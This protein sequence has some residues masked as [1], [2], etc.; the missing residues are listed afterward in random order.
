[1]ERLSIAQPFPIGR[2]VA[3]GYYRNRGSRQFAVLL[4]LTA[5][6]VGSG[7]A[8][9]AEDASAPELKSFRFSPDTIQTSLDAA[10]LTISFTVTDDDSG[11]TYFEAV[12][13]DQSGTARQSAS[14]RF[15]PTNRAMSSIKVNFPRFSNSGTW[16]LVQLFLSDAAGNTSSWDSEALARRGFPTRLEVVSAKDTVSPKLTALEFSPADP[17]TSAGPA[18]VSVTYTATDDLSGVSYVE[19]GFVSP[20]GTARQSR[21]MKFNASKVIANTMTVVFPAHSEPGQ[22]TL[23]SIFVMDAASNTLVLD[24]KAVEALGF[25]TLLNVRSTLDTVSPTLSSLTFAPSAIDTTGG[26]ANVTA[27]F[28]ATDDMSGVKSFEI[29]FTSPSGAASRSSVVTFAPAKKVTHS[30]SVNFP[31]LS[32]PGSWTLTSVVV[33]DAAGNTLVVDADMLP[34]VV[35]KTLEVR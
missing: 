2:G 21:S 23:N 18:E 27:Q 12:F 5:S 31:R 13:E 19:L 26:E 30:L 11:L 3:D 16:T 14:A 8:F 35:A 32:E 10:E 34:S 28:T 33:T 1:M 24:T 29:V 7:S 15:A 9:C 20:S 6:L 22:W 17:D 4:A 25:P